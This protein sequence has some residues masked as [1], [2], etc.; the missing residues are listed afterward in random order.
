MEPG[1]TL[2]PA[3]HCSTPNPLPAAVAGPGTRGQHCQPPPAAAGRE[4][5]GSSHEDGEPSAPGLRSRPQHGRHHRHRPLTW[6][7]Q[8][9]PPEHRIHQP[10][11]WS[12]P[13]PAP[14]APSCE[15]ERDDGG[16][17]EEEKPTAVYHHPVPA[18]GLW[19]AP[20]Q[21]RTRWPRA[22]PTW[23]GRG[24]ARRPASSCAATPPDERRVPP[25]PS[26]VASSVGGA[27]GRGEGRGGGAAARVGRPSRPAW[28]G[29]AGCERC[30]LK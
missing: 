14:S 30:D 26:R 5:P 16:E 7:C 12:S 19:L 3:S 24:D 18:Q 15:E 9:R 28:E 22:S 25:Q 1:F 17:E 27:S 8:I 6:G 21:S 10:R 2:P 4:G 11:A 13:S 29:D 20:P 23:L